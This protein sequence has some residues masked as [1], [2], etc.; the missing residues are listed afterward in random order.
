MATLK[1]E[2]TTVEVQE[3]GGSWSALCVTDLSGLGGGQASVIDLTTLCSE[4]K[5]KAM[6]LPD[7]GQ[8]SLSVFYDPANSAHARMLYLRENQ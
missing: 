1:S 4:A 5:E 8:I 6:G 2:G 7:E 3:S